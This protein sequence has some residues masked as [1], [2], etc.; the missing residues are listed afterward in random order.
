MKTI[1]SLDNISFA[2]WFRRQGGSNGSIKRM[3]NPIA[4]ALVLSTASIF[5][6]VA[7]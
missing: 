2:D 3:W 4:Y 6:L 7:C 1:R 5:L